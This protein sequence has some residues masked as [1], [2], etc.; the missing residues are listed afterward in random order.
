[1]QLLYLFL[2][3]QERHDFKLRE[4]SKFKISLIYQKDKLIF[5]QIIQTI[6]RNKELF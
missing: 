6:I 4:D 1:M 2:N 5:D 3:I